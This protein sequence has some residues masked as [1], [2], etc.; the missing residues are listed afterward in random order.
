MSPRACALAAFAVLQVGLQGAYAEAAPRNA[1]LDQSGDYGFVGTPA[2]PGQAPACL[3]QH[4]PATAAPSTPLANAVPRILYLNRNGGTYSPS[5]QND[6]SQNQ[7][8]IPDYTTTIA[9]WS[10]SDSSW[11]QVV[12]CV[13]ELYARW[14]LTVVDTDPGSV[15]H[16][17]VVVGGQPGDLNLPTGVGGI[18]PFNCN[19]IERSIAFVFA[20]AYQNNLR[21]ICEA[22]AHEAGHSFG[23]EHEF[24]C[25]D[26]MTYLYGCGDKTFQDSEE[27]CGTGAAEACECGSQQQNTVTILFDHLGAS[28]ETECGPTLPCEDGY[29]C[30]DGACVPQAGDGDGDGDGD[31]AGDGDGDGDSGGIG[32]GDGDGDGD[33]GGISGGDGGSTGD[34]DGNDQTEGA[35][36]T[37]PLVG[38]CGIAGSGRRSGSSILLLAFALLATAPLRRRR[39]RAG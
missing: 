13:S 22:I 23:L 27:S 33:S 8:S 15:A 38:G 34:G 5:N 21:G 39:V 36:D 3:Y 9:S 16:V 37:S 10:V 29:E 24:L 18:S 6:S 31:T 26:P 2:G 32:D 19:V 35:D 1:H 20:Q 7:S 28:E 4:V 11:N 14:N 25:K 17:E 30:V 12:D